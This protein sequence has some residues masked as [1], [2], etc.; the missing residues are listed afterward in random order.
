MR[1]LHILSLASV[2]LIALAGSDARA[3]DQPALSGRVSSAYVP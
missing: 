2:S 1:S 3:A